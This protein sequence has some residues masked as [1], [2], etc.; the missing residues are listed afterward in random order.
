MPTHPFDF[1]GKTVLITGA[2]TGIGRA[3]ALA[4]ASNGANVVIGDVDA[5]A[6]DTVQAIKEQGGVAAFVKT[7]VAN[8]ASVEALVAF[9][10]QRF[11]KIDAAFNN[12][13]ILPPTAPL[14]RQ[15]EANF[16]R[17]LSVDLKGVF[18]CMK[19]QIQAMLQSG[20]GPSSIPPLWPGWWPTRAWRPMSRP[21]MAWSG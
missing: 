4:F 19:F 12:A 3:T 17:V 10:V 8:S 13:G 16:D 1:V 11:G 9:A 14:A 18:L 7:D 20:G 6:A 21:S 5:R 15:S 2:A